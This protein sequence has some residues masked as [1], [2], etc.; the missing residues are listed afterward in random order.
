MRWKFPIPSWA[1]PATVL[2]LWVCLFCGCGGPKIKYLKRGDGPVVII[3]DSLAAGFGAPEGEGF[4]DELERRL[5]VEIINKG[6]K[7]H[8]TVQGMARLQKDVLELN[9]SLVMLELGG[10][11][12]LQKLDVNQTFVNLG[13]MINRIHA[14]EVPVLLLGVRGGIMSDKY[15]GRYE[16]LAR[17]KGVAVVPNI[18]EGLLTQPAYKF[19]AIHPNAA[20]YE[21][22]ADR[23]EP[24]LKPMLEA[25]GKL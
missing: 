13:E 25:V 23:I 16:E 15:A 18:V 24:V 17:Q 11:D 2:T 3:G 19:D 22:V 5:G 6:I 7:G 8:T 10:N 9:P 4:V 12:A 1:L 21:K 14:Q 20:G